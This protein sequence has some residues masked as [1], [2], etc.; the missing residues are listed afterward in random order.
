MKTKAG[1]MPTTKA[2]ADHLGCSIRTLRRAIRAGRIPVV[3]IGPRTVRI[4]ESAL[5][6]LALSQAR[7]DGSE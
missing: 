6:A 2:A 5:V 4:P 7:G 1:R 3:R